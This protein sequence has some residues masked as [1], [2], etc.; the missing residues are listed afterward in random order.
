MDKPIQNLLIL[1]VGMSIACSQ[2]EP[3]FKLPDVQPPVATVKPFEIT[4]KHGHTRVD[5]Y[6]WLNDRE[7]QEVI[8]YLNAENAYLDTMMAHTKGFQEDLF[9]EM[10]SRIKEDDSS[11]PYKLDDY[12][13]YSRYVEGGEYPI[14][15]RKKGSLDAK[16]EIV[17]DGNELGKG[18]SYL[19]FFTSVSEDHNLAAIIMDTVGRNFYTVVIKDLQTG[20]MLPDRIENIRSSAVW[21]NDNKSF[22]Y[23]IPDPVTLRNFQVKRHVLGEDASKDEIIFEEKDQTLS[24]GVGKTKSKKY[25][26]IGSGRT[27]ASYAMYLEADKPG[28]LKPIA[29]LQ[30]NV[31][32]DVDHAGGDRFYIY[33]NQDA[34]NYRLVEAPISNPSPSNWNDVI[35]NRP[36]IFLEGVDY[37]KDYMAVQETKEGLAKIRIIKYEDQSEHEL[38]FGE[39]AY[40]A[41][42][43]YNPAFDTDVLR[44][45]YT[46]MTT[47]NSVYDYNMGSR[48][49]TLM[50]EQPVLGDF[51]KEN[52]QTERVMVTARDGKKV[53]MSIV[54]H[55]DKF[56][57]DGSMPGWIYAYGSYGYSMDPTFSSTRLSLLD[58]GFVYAIAHIRGGQEMGGDWYEDGKMMNK[59][60]TF[61]D[62]IDCSKWLQE[63]KYVAKDRLFASG[64][65]AGGLLMGGV[66]NMAPE[67]YRGV[68]AAVAFVDVV[69]TMMDETIPLTTF[70]W[71]E[72]GNPNIQ[73]Q[74]EYMLS[75]SPYDNVEAKDYPHI[76]ATTGLHDSQVQYWEPAK[77]VAKLRTLKTDDNRLFLYTNMDAGH[78]GASGRFESLKELAREFAFVFDIL[79][80]KE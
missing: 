64:G 2:Q 63:N 39:P 38:E 71:L 17:M 36:D 42:L 60:N 19:N 25:I 27:D 28:K 8:D 18:K 33:T 21:A 58:R 24:C 11:V 48:E 53:P 66:L 51:N 6:Y 43:G 44:Y 61:T 20:E 41:G 1:S 7:D 10:R 56:K 73:E 72:W 29:P 40:T 69:T 80:I 30:D 50:K 3:E 14:Y 76:L 79:G 23:S 37:F 78:G 75:Y 16:E 32:Y 54:Y 57:K 4:A 12:Y 47:P 26:I 49:K 77:W 59:K 45:S 74:Y 22:Y 31:Q 46:S 35:P 68:I 62:F 9:K 55:K 15:A 5:D 34:V 67:V 65:S 13:Y 52:Y 70:E